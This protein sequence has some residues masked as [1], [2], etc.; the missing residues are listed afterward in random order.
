MYLDTRPP[1]PMMLAAC[2]N[3][4]LGVERGDTRRVELWS[5][6]HTHTHTLVCHQR[7]DP[8]NEQAD[9]RRHRGCGQ[10]AATTAACVIATLPAPV[11]E[12]VDKTVRRHCDLSCCRALP[13][14]LPSGNCCSYHLNRCPNLTYSNIT[15]STTF[16]DLF[17][18]VCHL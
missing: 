12:S 10:P 17:F 16:E 18:Q 6:T 4:E 14:S 7:L 8:R 1:Y 15:S 11:L 5:H 3:N 13:L 9:L 2:L